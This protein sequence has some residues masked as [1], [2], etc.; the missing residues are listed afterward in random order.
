MITRRSQYI[1]VGIS[2]CLFVAVSGLLMHRRFHSI[3]RWFSGPHV[4]VQ[5]VPFERSRD[6]V[7]V[8]AL[9]EQDRYWLIASENYS[10]D[11]MLEHKAPNNR[12]G[13]YLGTLQIDVL[14]AGTEM[15]GFVAYYDRALFTGWILFLVVDHR[16]R[17]HGYGARLIDHAVEVFK[18]RGMERVRLVARAENKPAHAV[19]LSCGFKAIRTTDEG[20][21]GQFIYFEKRLK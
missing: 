13:T 3:K 5:I 9:L 14:Y 17:G 15:A 4:A 18:K 1:I 19:Y 20:K 12:E 7:A 10:V 2:A 6:E 11:F 21:E 8:R 16:Y